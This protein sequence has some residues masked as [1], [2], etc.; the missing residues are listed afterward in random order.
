MV[1]HCLTDRQR[2]LVVKAGELADR[3]AKR[4]GEHDRDNTF[5]HENYAELRAAGFLRLTVPVELGGQGA[6]LDEVLPVLERLA[7]GDA[8]TALAVTMHISPLGQWA[9]VWRQTGNPR[10]AELLRMAAEDKL[11]WASV[12]AEPGLR[13]DMTDARTT[14]VKVGGGFRLTGRK[15]YATNTVVATHCSTTARWADADGGPRLVLCRIALDAPGV[16]LEQTWD[17]MGMRGTQSNDVVYDNVFVADEDVVH[18]L[19]IGHLDARVFETVWSW[20]LAAFGAVYTGIAAGAVDWTIEMVK[21]MGKERDPLVMD[22][23][24]ECEILIESARALLFR[25]ADEVTSRRI[26]ELD[27][28]A[29]IAR[30]AMVKYVA[31]NNATKVLQ[32]L[33]DVIGGA[34]YTRTLPF[35][36]MW[37]DA[38]AGVFMPMAN[39][40]ARTFVG[41]SALGVELA[42]VIGF[43]ETGP[44]SRAQS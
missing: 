41:A 16:S 1:M 28:Q 33:V 22:A 43:A 29:G 5:P 38:Q 21:R 4:A 40:R 19:P 18:S 15:T 31:S 20:A 8:S 30:C 36:R 6:T 32:K 37:R 23:I 3:F 42:P 9:S 27:V 24:A 39:N 25:H 34:S 14:A 13:N 44:D 7:M 12:T 11:I 2:E 17:T 35:E 10:L 26:F